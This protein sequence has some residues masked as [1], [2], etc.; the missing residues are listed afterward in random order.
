L[1]SFAPSQPRTLDLTFPIGHLVENVDLTKKELN[2][3]LSNNC[4]TQDSSATVSSRLRVVFEYV[5]RIL[6]SE[7]TSTVDQVEYGHNVTSVPIQHAFNVTNLGPSPLN[8]Q[9]SYDV[10]IPDV[11]FVSFI[12]VSAVS[13]CRVSTSGR[14]R[15]DVGGGVSA[16]TEL[17]SCGTYNCKI[18]SCSLPKGAVAGSG[19]ALLVNLAF[20]PVAASK[21][22]EGVRKNFAVVT[23][24]RASESNSPQD[25]AFITTELFSGHASFVQESWP[26][27]VGAGIGLILLVMLVIVL[28]KSKA[29]SKM[30]I[31]KSQL[32][33]AQKLVEPKAEA[34]AD[35][36]T[37]LIERSK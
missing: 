29:F 20:D 31:Y 5:Y 28:W 11:D 16:G 21:R 3:Y 30:R 13:R 1:P 12:N 14:Q 34:G 26:Y 9:V 35:Q 10:F 19:E 8:R 36:S 6:V 2:F 33:D 27:L 25:F 22:H 32:E 17:V 18:L 4:S 23:L 7:L 37:E 24:A 15:V